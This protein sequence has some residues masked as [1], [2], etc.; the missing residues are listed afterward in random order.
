MTRLNYLYCKHCGI[1]DE[2]NPAMK[3]IYTIAEKNIAS[4]NSFL[5][6]ITCTNCKKDYRMW[7]CPEIGITFKTVSLADQKAIDES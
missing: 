5:V 3:E 6:R 7:A 1:S 4:G 2:T